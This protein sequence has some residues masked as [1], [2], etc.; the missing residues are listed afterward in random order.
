MK[1]MIVIALA[2]ASV[3][4]YASDKKEINAVKTTPAV[5]VNEAA[6]IVKKTKSHSKKM[7]KEVKSA[8]VS[9]PV[10]STTKK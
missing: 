10:S 6:P 4:S 8:A 3:A 7:V 9:A 5:A 1:S 2:L